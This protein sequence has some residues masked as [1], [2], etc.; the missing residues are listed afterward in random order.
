MRYSPSPWSPAPENPK[1][2]NGLIHLWRFRL[3]PSPTETIK[4]KHLLS[5][6]E[7]SR[8]DR[9]IDPAKANQFMV[10]RGRLRQIL[11]KYCA[12]LPH[13]I[14]FN[15][16]ENGKPALKNN[17]ALQLAFNLSHAGHWSVLAVTKETEVGVDIETIDQKIDHEKVA[18]G[19]FSTPEIDELEQYPPKR[20]RRAFYRIWTRKEA[21]LKLLG[22]GFSTPAA[23]TEETGQPI[24]SFTVSRDYLGAIAVQKEINAVYRYDFK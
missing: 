15:Y 19:F 14:R 11:A 17:T 16:G 5:D 18:A 22:T 6:D 13:Q 12:L 23:I 4:L 24:K 3:D 7:R 8:A 2:T 9:L 1:L 10:A 21:R 20:R